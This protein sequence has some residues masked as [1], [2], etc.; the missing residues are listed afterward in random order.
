[1]G[2]CADYNNKTAEVSC[3]T[4]SFR[5]TMEEPMHDTSITAL[6]NT[7][8]S[9]LPIGRQLEVYSCYPYEN[10]QQVRLTCC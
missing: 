8:R 2:H 10:Q 3:S 7:A 4:A 1:M 6:A 9:P 5:L